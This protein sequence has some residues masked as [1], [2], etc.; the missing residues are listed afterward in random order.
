MKKII[1]VLGLLSVLG[2]SG[3]GNTGPLYM[4]QD[5]TQAEETQS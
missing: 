3:C 4:P 5:D 1:I 2:L